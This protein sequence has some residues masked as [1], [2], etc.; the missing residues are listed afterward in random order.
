MNPNPFNGTTTISYYV[1][2]NKAIQINQSGKGAIDLKASDIPLGVYQYSLVVNE[3]V[4]DEKQM[5]H[6]K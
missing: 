4:I 6:T 2:I 1:P 3:K 5:L